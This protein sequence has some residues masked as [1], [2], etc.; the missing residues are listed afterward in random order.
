MTNKPLAF[1]DVETT[2]TNAVSGRIIEIGIIKIEDDKIITEFQTLINP[3]MRVDPFIE[4]MT[5]INPLEL[6]N[7]PLFSDIKEEV[8]GILEDSIFV[9]HNV[10]FDYGFIRNEFKR[11]GINFTSKHFDTVKLARVLYPGHTHY[12]LDSIMSR[13]GIENTDRHRAFGDAKVLWDFFR[14]SKEQIEKNVF[15]AA[16]KLVLKKPS[17][18]ASIPQK[19]ID[20]LPE[21]PGVYIFS[22]ED[23]APLYIG[24]S[25]N[26][27]ERV[28]SHFTNDYGSQTDMK[29]TQTAKSVEAI[30]TAGELSALLLES[31]LIKTQQ[32]MYNRMLRQSKN[33]LV[34]IRVVDKNGYNSVS[35]KTVEEIV[36][37]DIENILGVFKNQK[38]LKDY[39]YEI[40]K[41][42]KLCPK[43]MGLE[44]GKGPCFYYQLKQ[45]GGACMK[46]E[47]EMKYNLRFEEAFFGKK[48]KSWKFDGPVLVKEMGDK[49]EIHVIDKWCYLGS[50]KNESESLEKLAGDYHFD[51]DV[52]KILKR[53]L[54][55]PRNLKNVSFY[56][57][58][59]E[60]E[61]VN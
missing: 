30:E 12:N 45:C 48:V 11:V 20:K 59:D 10:R 39:L 18:P 61:S 43:V 37:A 32:P 14:I 2:G 23:G 22:G 24:K 35:I 13:H 25:V 16:L 19:V 29:I 33:M 53:Y 57:R 28:L 47:W 4:Q 54:A 55:N 1:V 46:K 8:Y 31:S 51:F 3:E 41:E 42:H 49:N 6:E 15:D 56:Y 50:I 52:Y 36:V 26:I 44:K 21:T 7:A 58:N 5:G 40:C 38:Q 9:A 27:K 34:I 60:A 17:L